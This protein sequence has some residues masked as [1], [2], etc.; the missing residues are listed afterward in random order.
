M[1]TR[2]V[3]R[4]IIRTA[5]VLA[6][7]LMGLGLYAI[8]S[9]TAA[10][11]APAKAA[12]GTRL[13]ARPGATSVPTAAAIPARGEFDC[14]GDSPVE[15]ATRPML[16]TDIRGFLG[17]DNA[18]TWGGRFYDNGH[19]IGHD[20]PDMT[21]L[22]SRPGSGSNVTWTE[23]LP[24]D[25][26]TAPTVGTPGQDVADW[27][28]LSPAPWFSM[29]MCDP[30]SYPQLPCVPRSDANAPSCDSAN[31]PSNAYPGGGSAF[32]EMQ[33]YPPGN[34]PWID[35]ESCSDAGWCAALT[36]DSQI[37]RAHV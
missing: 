33:L 20:E 3:S 28:E 13:V 26:S 16:C 29:A 32:M 30:Y 34:P 10:R 24:V 37:G 19:Y 2:F 6:V 23:T 36:I 11:A 1:S 5:A 25:P 31:C 12:T 9:A 22:S 7:T 14:N 27:F 4:G 17:V 8:L 21:F 35:S 18:N 15:T